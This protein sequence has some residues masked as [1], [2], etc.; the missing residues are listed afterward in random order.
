MFISFSTTWKDTEAG[1][2]EEDACGE[3]LGESTSVFEHVEEH[4]VDIGFGEFVVFY[5]L[6]HVE[7]VFLF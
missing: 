3:D 4:G 2:G 5:G 1:L 6:F 7:V